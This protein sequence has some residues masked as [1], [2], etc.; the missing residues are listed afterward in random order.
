MD[1]LLRLVEE[2]GLRIVEEQG[3][4]RGGFDPRSRTIRV[5]PGMSVRTTRSVIA[6]EL[7]HAVLGHVATADPAARARQEERADDWAAALLISPRAYAEAEAARGPHPASLA[8]DLG[9]T[10]ELVLAFQRVLA[11]RRAA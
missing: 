9:V 1:Q 6:H 5:R 8:F 11:R 10:I 2:H 4:T 3:V 7:G